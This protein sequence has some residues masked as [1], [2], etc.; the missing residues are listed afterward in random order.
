MVKV[1]GGSRQ[2]ATVRSV[3]LE[4][5]VDYSKACPSTGI[6]LT[7]DRSNMSSYKRDGSL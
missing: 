3:G 2:V 1:L 5:E 4:I 7:D 6:I